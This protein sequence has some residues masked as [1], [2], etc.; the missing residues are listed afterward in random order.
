MALKLYKD[1]SMGKNFKGDD[2]RKLPNGAGYL[3]IREA[4][5]TVIDRIEF[6]AQE[7]V[8]L[9]GHIK[10]KMLGKAG[11]EVMAKDINLTGQNRNIICA[12]A[13][14]IGYLYRDKQ[15]TVL[16]FASSDEVL[17]GSRMEHLRGQQIIL[18]EEKDGVVTT[19]W[20][21]VYIP[22]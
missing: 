21:K 22:E 12:N 2:V 6:A 18:G 5:E 10:D 3:Y 4:F 14:A 20:D 9:V 17:C 7:G 13:D 1:T 19:H 8:I 15:N 11:K 16:N